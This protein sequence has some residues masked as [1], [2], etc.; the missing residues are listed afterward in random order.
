MDI[1]AWLNSVDLNP[2]TKRKRL[3][4]QAPLPPSPPMSATT[5]RRPK[6]QRTLRDEDNVDAGQSGD[7]EITPRAHLPSSYASTSSRSS[8]SGASS[9]RKAMAALGIGNETGDYK[10]QSFP[11]SHEGI[12]A[13]RLPASLLKILKEIKSMRLGAVPILDQNLRV[14]LHLPLPRSLG[15][16]AP[17]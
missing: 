15:M 14:R 4:D 9:P 5:P 6:R 10:F 13:H 12:N 2:P 8:Q 3:A 17:N 1:T 7:T 16:P 11:L